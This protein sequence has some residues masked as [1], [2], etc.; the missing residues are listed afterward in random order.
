MMAIND[1]E[2]GIYFP[3]PKHIYFIHSFLH[4]PLGI[5]DDHSFKADT[6]Y[7]L[8]GKATKIK[9]DHDMKFRNSQACE[10]SCVTSGDIIQ[11]LNSRS[12]TFWLGKFTSPSLRIFI[13]NMRLK[14]IK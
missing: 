14:E 11:L 9:K 7:T 13:Y 5:H 2:V 12:A 4:Y 3:A 8:W 1:R 10:M 6:S